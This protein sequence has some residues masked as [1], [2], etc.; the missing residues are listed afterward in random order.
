MFRSSLQERNVSGTSNRTAPIISREAS[1][2]SEEE[3]RNREN[4]LVKVNR[5][6]ILPP[7]VKKMLS[8]YNSIRIRKSICIFSRI[9]I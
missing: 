6:I 1:R 8:Q 3:E 5:V 2:P 4:E 7:L 9:L